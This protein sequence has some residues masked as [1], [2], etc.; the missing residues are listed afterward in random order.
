MIF[1]SRLCNYLD[2]CGRSKRPV[3][4]L[5]WAQLRMILENDRNRIRCVLLVL[6]SA[7]PSG[8][9]VDLSGLLHQLCFWSSCPKLQCALQRCLYEAPGLTPGEFPMLCNFCGVWWT[10]RSSIQTLFLMTRLGRKESKLFP[11]TSG[12][13]F[14]F[15][16]CFSLWGDFLGFGH[17]CAAWISVFQYSKKH[18]VDSLLMAHRRNIDELFDLRTP[19][20]MSTVSAR[21][22]MGKMEIRVV[23][24]IFMLF[25]CCFHTFSVENYHHDFHG[26][27][28]TWSYDSSATDEECSCLSS[29][30]RPWSTIRPQAQ[31]SNDKNSH[32]EFQ[33]DCDVAGNAMLMRV[34]W[35]GASEW[36][37][38]TFH[39][40]AVSLPGDSSVQ[41]AL[42]TAGS[43]RPAVKVI[44]RV[45]LIFNFKGC[46][47][48]FR[49][50]F[51]FRIF[52]KFG[53]SR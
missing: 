52:E 50:W 5:I 46:T 7:W 11:R 53:I 45:V 43:W 12:E 19:A 48:W 24:C 40:T 41:R 51:R 6:E 32:N 27:S 13:F 30:S 14:V 23:S 36:R 35:W 49:S 9:H 25:S 20:G 38:T 34:P 22:Q 33:K 18:L 2:N 15:L 42:P 26:T 8:W 1:M 29:A 16:N 39:V 31:H 47:S 17:D 10:L 44:P 37:F 3:R 21:V 4:C 28:M